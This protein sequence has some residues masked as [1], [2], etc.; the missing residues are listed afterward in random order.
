MPA[1]P[2]TP[3]AERDRWN[4]IDSDSSARRSSGDQPPATLPAM[5]PAIAVAGPNTELE[6]DLAR[7]LGRSPFSPF[8]PFS[9]V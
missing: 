2:S 1:T 4:L 3:D 6:L 5:M 7:R 8:S 9:G